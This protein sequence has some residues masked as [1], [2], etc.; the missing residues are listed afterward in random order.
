STETISLAGDWRF[1]LDRKNSGIEERWLAQKLPDHIRL[2]GSL[3]EQGVGDDIS[4]NTQWTGDIVDKSWFTAP[5]YAKYRQPGNVKIPFWLQPEKYY[6]GATWYQRE[7]QIP[8]GWVAKRVI[9]SLERPH[10][11]TRVWLDGN[12]VGSNNSLSTP[13]EYDFGAALKPGR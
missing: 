11:E 13:H 8:A 2:P 4:I 12:E 9:L 1:Q 3:P 10:W 6:A 7:L 5:E